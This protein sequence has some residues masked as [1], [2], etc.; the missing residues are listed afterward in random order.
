MSKYKY[1]SLL[2][3]ILLVCTLV[4]GIC[5]PLFS[6]NDNSK[7]S[8]GSQI[9]ASSAAATQST[10][11]QTA[12]VTPSEEYKNE[13]TITQGNAYVIELSDEETNAL[14]SFESSN[15]SVVSVDSGGRIDAVNQGSALINAEFSD[16][17]KYIYKVN[18]NEAE[19]SDYDGFSTCILSNQDILERNTTFN[20]GSKNLYKIM[21]NK[22]QNCVTVYT[23]DL[24]GAYTVPVRAMVCSCGLNGATITGSFSIYFRQEWN[25]LYN[26]VYGYYVSGISGDYLF[27]S[28]PFYAPQPDMLEV[29]EFNKLG[30]EASLGCIR[31]AVGDTKWIYDN[32]TVGTDV[33]IY[34]SEEPGPLGKPETIKITDFNCGWDPTDSN[35]NN[36][37]YFK[38][39]VISGAQDK[40]ISKGSSFE[41]LN[42]ITAT[43]T[44]GND[45]SGKIECMGNVLTS[46]PGTYKLT[47]RVTDALHRTSS[48]DITITVQ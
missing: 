34:E 41:P 4:C 48:T 13:I 7:S 24:D 12:T 17:K 11:R 3:I 15:S 44:C 14:Q 40:S 39:P 1:L 27:H 22:T 8:A 42:G 29:E 5:I 47:Y 37:Y 36:P 31:M 30:N 21:V 10:T 25:P 2:C 35:E 28:V 16:N 43:D 18:V 6:E 9:S 26:N 45:I 19:K 20:D 33:E 38:K 32:C 46:K 23:Y